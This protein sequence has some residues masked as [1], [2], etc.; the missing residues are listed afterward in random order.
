MGGVLLIHF[1][2]IVAISTEHSL[3]TTILSFQFFIRFLQNYIAIVKSRKL[4]PKLRPKKPLPASGAQEEESI[5]ITET[6]CWTRK[7]THT[8]TSI[9]ILKILYNLYSACILKATASLYWDQCVLQN[10]LLSESVSRHHGAIKSPASV[11]SQW[12][13]RATM[14]MPVVLY[15]SSL[16]P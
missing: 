15:W 7:H 4:R 11:G 9:L 5:V 13:C 14:K 10:F 12:L 8:T 3:K 16:K 2:W 1:K 6:F